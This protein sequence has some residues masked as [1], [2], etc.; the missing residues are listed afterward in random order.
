MARQAPFPTRRTYNASCCSEHPA[1]SYPPHGIRTGGVSCQL[2]HPCLGVFGGRSVLL[3]RPPA[4]S[5]NA[6]ENTN[7]YA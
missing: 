1:L 6:N 7:N 2:S 5:L 4:P 3:N